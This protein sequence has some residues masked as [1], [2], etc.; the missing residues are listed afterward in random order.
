MSIRSR[1]GHWL[2]DVKTSAVAPLHAIMNMGHATWSKREYAEFADEG[3]RK[4]VIAYKAINE[5][6]T[7]VQLI[8]WEVYKVDNQGNKMEADG[9]PLAQLLRRPNPQQGM[10]VFFGDLCGFDNIAG[11]IYIE[12]VKPGPS[13]PPLELYALRPDRMTVVAGAAGPGGYKY[14]VGG[15]TK[16]W[17]ADEDAIRHIKRFNPTDDWYGLS[18]IEAAAFSIDIHNSTLEW[19]KALLD[20]GARPSGALVYNPKRDTAPDF[21]PDEQ[22]IKL[23]QD[24]NEQYSGKKHA[25]KPMLLEGG[26]MWQQFSLSPA[27]MD[28][29]N[30]KET[31]ARDIA[32]AFGVP[33]Q[34]LGIPGDNTYS[35]MQ[36]AR[37]AL[38]EDTVI[39]WARRLRDELN[40]WLAPQY[41]DATYIIEIDEDDIPALAPRRAE[42]WDKVNNADFLTVNEKRDATGYENAGKAADDIYIPA[43][44]IPLG[45]NLASSQESAAPVSNREEE[46]GAED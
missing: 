14:T 34:L 36:E 2:L 5:L 21:L 45:A 15:E 3:Y 42:L 46:P 35:N 18:P 28:Y 12:A 11:N 6:M 38:Y 20:N 1:I 8:P 37:L 41:R 17:P 9:S 32:M 24:V 31:S 26:L 43:T 7:A 44:L 13:R 10:G 23:K 39:P 40:A 4:N 29:I 33:A 25:G 16:T 27:D 22:F 19:N 30:S